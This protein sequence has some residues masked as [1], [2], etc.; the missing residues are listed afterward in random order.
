LRKFGA[1]IEILNLCERSQLIVR[2]GSNTTVA[3]VNAVAQR[4]SGQFGRKRSAVL[5]R[6]IRETAAGIETVGRTECTCGASLD[7]AQAVATMRRQRSVVMVGRCGKDEFAKEKVAP[8]ARNYELCVATEPSKS[9]SPR[10]IVL[11]DGGCVAESAP[12]RSSVRSLAHKLKQSCE[13]L[14]HHLVVVAPNGVA[15]KMIAAEGAGI[16]LIVVQRKTDDGLRT[17]NQEAGI[18]P[19]VK[20]VFQ[21]RHACVVVMGKIVLPLPT[22]P[23]LYRSGRR[24][25]TNRKAEAL[26]FGFQGCMAEEIRH[27]RVSIEFIGTIDTIG[28]IASIK[29]LN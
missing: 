28:T 15:G 11:I 9:A 5:N 23:L 29:N 16:A 1:R 14:L 6:E 27:I 13:A 22:S 24:T 19:L 25:A 18:E 8:G 10:P 12:I 3:A 17:V 20:M 4:R 21:I 7:T 2:A 26:G